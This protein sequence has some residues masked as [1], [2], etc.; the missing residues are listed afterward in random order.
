MLAIQDATNVQLA[1]DMDGHLGQELEDHLR[2]FAAPYPDRFLIFTQ[3]WFPRVME[4]GAFDQRVKNLEAAKAK[5]ARGIKI[6]KR[7]GLWTR[8]A[9]GQRVRLDDPRLDPLWEAAGRLGLPLLIHVG[10][11]PAFFEPVDAHNE[12]YEELTYNVPEWALT[13]PAFPAPQTVLAEFER[14]LARHPRTTFI[15]AHLVSASHDLAWV[16]RL[17]EAHPNLYVDTAAV[18]NEVGRQPVTARAF[19]IRYADRILFGTDGNP[20]E[21]RYRTY[22]R[23][24]ETADEHFDHPA[25]PGYRAGRWKIYGLSL[26]EDAL[27]NIYHDNAAKLLGLPLVAGSTKRPT[28]GED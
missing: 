14:V 13:D 16:G 1:V 10:D 3:V 19:F 28:R 25:R 5:G 21:A 12:R 11:P 22:F 7:L 6:W 27:R 8:E 17:L 20:D 26:P 24:F 18:G 15:G 9:N 23:L 2:R 4:W